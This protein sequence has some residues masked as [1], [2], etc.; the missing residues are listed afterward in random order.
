M[1]IFRLEGFNGRL[2]AAEPDERSRY[3]FTIWFPYTRE[4]VNDIQDGDLLAVP[5]FQSDRERPVYSILKVTNVLPK[6]FAL[7]G[8]E[9]TK[10]YPG[11]VLEAAKNIAA[12]WVIQESE[13]LEDTTIIEVEAIPT[14][15]QFRLNEQNNPIIEEEKSMPMVGEEVKLLSPEFVM[16]IL[17]SGIKFGYE[18]IIEIGHLIRDKEIKIYVR[19]EDLVRT[20]FGIFGYTGV[21]KSNLLSTIIRKLLTETIKIDE[22]QLP[23]KEIRERENIKIL[24]FDLMDEYISLLIDLL[25]NNNLDSKIVYIDRRSL[26]KAVI[27]YLK[28]NETLIKAIHAFLRQMY[29]PKG[30]L[31]CK[32]KYY[33]RI[34]EILEKDRIKI[35]EEEFEIKTIDELIEKIWPEVIGD[36]RSTTKI[37]TLER[38]KEDI[39]SDVTGNELT[40]ENLDKILSKLGES[41]VFGYPQPQ[42]VIN[43]RKQ[44]DG[45]ASVMFIFN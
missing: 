39:L 24:L 45:N 41:S 4:L 44:K 42:S 9:D 21:G 40:P 16:K 26:P 34:R 5:N 43:L 30:L 28:G 19:V 15:L 8:K 22:K 18:E 3:N 32:D 20:H 17:N 38:V 23:K 6:H 10:S 25:V 2:L 35:W 31:D 33:E 27:D 7:R 36:L 11:Y 14:N 29:I 37:S 13:P 12:S 1:E